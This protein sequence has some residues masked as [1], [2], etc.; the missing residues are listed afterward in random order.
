[1]GT[2]RASLALVAAA[3]LAASGCRSGIADAPPSPTD[4]R[5]RRPA[6]AHAGHGR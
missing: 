2:I 3:A 1:M 5:R 4:A 6:G